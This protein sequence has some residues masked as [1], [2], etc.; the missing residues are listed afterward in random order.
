MAKKLI[1]KIYTG[2]WNN[3]ELSKGSKQAV[4]NAG[5]IL[6]AGVIGAILITKKKA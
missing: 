4:N 6:L 1:D 3:L 5:L 2:A